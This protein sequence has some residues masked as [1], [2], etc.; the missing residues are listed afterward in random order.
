MYVIDPIQSLAFSIHSSPGVYAFLLGSGVSRAANIPT[1]WEVTLDLIRR[2]AAVTGADPEPDPAAWYRDRF[3]REPEYSALLED[4]AKTPTER[5]QL[6]RGYFQPTNDTTGNSEG[7]PTAAHHAIATLVAKGYVRV[8]LTTNFD[9]LLETALAE[10]NVAPTVLSSSDQIRGSLPL[11]HT[12][13]CVFK[14]HGDYLDSRILNTDQELASYPDEH[15]HLLDRVF[16]DFGLIVCGWSGDWDEALRSA[17]LR[18]T[19]RRFTTYWARHGELTD[20][21]RSLITHRKAQVIPIDSA[22]GFLSDLCEQVLAIANVGQPDPESTSIAVARLKEYLPEPR[23]RIRLSDL[24]DSTVQRFV[25]QVSAKSFSTDHA[26]E[27]STET[28]T[29]RI[30]AYEAASSRLLHLACVGGRWARR[31]HYAVWRRALQSLDSH[32]SQSGSAFWLA[33]QRYPQTLLLYALGLGALQTE[34]LAFLNHILCTPLHDRNDNDYPAVQTLP[35]IRLFSH[36]D[37]PMRILEGMEQRKYPLNDWIHDALQ[38]IVETEIPDP[39][40]YTLTFDKLEILIALSFAHRGKSFVGGWMPVGAFQY[41]HGNRDRVLREIRE[42]LADDSDSSVFVASGVFGNS[43]V[44]CENNLRRL[45][46]FLAQ[47]PPF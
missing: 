13:C 10:R 11:I 17:I 30:R 16:D 34:G 2:I 1:G 9:R 18:T 41:R 29:S 14:I 32:T 24:V 39:R 20:V 19:S 7:R 4:L 33:M 45:E 23:H 44:E 40:Q 38:P 27:V 22:D 43:S 28:V 47:L 25:T 31:E 8:I 15:N 35:P 26:P 46:D 5:Q 12:P 42:S 6:L 3:E 37:R 36:G 21:S